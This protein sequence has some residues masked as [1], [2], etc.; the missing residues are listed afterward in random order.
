MSK[1]ENTTKKYPKIW[2][3]DSGKHDAVSRRHI[4]RREKIGT[5]KG[6]KRSQKRKKKEIPSVRNPYRV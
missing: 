6:R 2:P 5:D 1:I 3:P 4:M